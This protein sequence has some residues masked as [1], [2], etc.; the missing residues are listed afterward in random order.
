MIFRRI[1]VY[2]NLRMYLR[3]V[4]KL[5]DAASQT[6]QF[7][8]EFHRGEIELPDSKN[9]AQQLLLARFWSCIH[10]L[11]PD[12]EHRKYVEPRHRLEQGRRGSSRFELSRLLKER[13]PHPSLLYLVFGFLSC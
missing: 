4:T 3:I 12:V 6:E 11:K 2:K 10:G 1:Q 7:P 9:H 8:H 13:Q 5:G